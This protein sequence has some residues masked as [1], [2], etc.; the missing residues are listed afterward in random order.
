MNNDIFREVGNRDSIRNT[1]ANRGRIIIAGGCDSGVLVEE[2][3]HGIVGF[4][5][6]QAKAAA[7][8][9]NNFMLVVH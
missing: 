2:D 5:L 6:A 9:L 3:S 1:R 8:N 4:G 7:G